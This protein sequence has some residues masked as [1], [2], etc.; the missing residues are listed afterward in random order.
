MQIANIAILTVI[1]A[2][3]VLIIIVSAA[4]VRLTVRLRQ[5]QQTTY[6]DLEV[7]RPLEIVNIDTFSLFPSSFTGQDDGVQLLLLE[8]DNSWLPP[9]ESTELWV[10]RQMTRPIEKD[11]RARAETYLLGAVHPVAG[12]TARAL[13]FDGPIRDSKD[14]RR[15]GIDGYR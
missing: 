4:L 11:D 2:L 13:S 1:V 8:Q 3:I 15:A 9:K 14:M 5:N 7:G 6:T 12:E 10:D